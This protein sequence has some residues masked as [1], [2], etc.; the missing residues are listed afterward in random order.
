MKLR[1][2][3]ALLAS[4]QKRIVLLEARVKDLEEKVSDLEWDLIQ[5]EDLI[6]NI[7]RECPYL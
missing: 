4:S 3:R 7:E 6:R 1:A 2:L 5:S